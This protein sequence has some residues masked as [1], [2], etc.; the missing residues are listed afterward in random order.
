MVSAQFKISTFWQLANSLMLL[1]V[2]KFD[3]FPTFIIIAA[4]DIKIIIYS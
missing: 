2:T 4:L 1:Q 3:Y